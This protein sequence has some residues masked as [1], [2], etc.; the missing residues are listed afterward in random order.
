MGPGAARS[1]ATQAGGATRPGVPARRPVGWSRWPPSWLRPGRDD[2]RRPASLF[3]DQVVAS[4]T[5]LV[6]PPEPGARGHRT[7]GPCGQVL[8][9]ARPA[10]EQED[11]ARCGD[12]G[13]SLRRAVVPAGQDDVTRLAHAVAG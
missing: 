8:P 9:V 10:V 7:D 2:D 6:R 5:V 1:P 4:V 11:A 12:D 13:G 3:G